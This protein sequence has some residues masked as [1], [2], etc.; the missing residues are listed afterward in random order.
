MDK[1]NK[2]LFAGK[3]F[4]Y[5]LVGILLA[6]L[7]ALTLM[8]P[9][10]PTF[11]KKET[12]KLLM[13][14][15]NRDLENIL[16]EYAAKENIKL[17]IDY[18]GTI[19]IMDKL[20]AHENYD[21]I[22]T[23]NSIW[24]Y[25]LENGTQVT[26]SKST[27]INPVVFGIKKTKAEA[28]GLVQEEI[29]TKD[30]LELILNK[31]LTFLMNA[32]TRTNTGATAYLGFLNTLA[33][34]PEVLTEEDLEQESLKENM[35]TLL[36]GVERTS[37]SEEFLE[38]LL[39]KQ[40]Y[41]AAL[42]YESSFITLNQ[43]LEKEGKEP[44]YLIYPV[45]GVTLSDSPFAYLG[46]DASKKEIFLKF[47]SY[48]LSKEG[49]KKLEALGRRT[50]Y[51]GIK[52]DTN[53]EIFNPDWGIDTTRYL[54]PVKY[55]S[56]SM[57]KKALVM[58]QSELRKPVHTIFVLDYSGSM[59]GDGQKQLYQAMDYILTE[60]KA[61]QNLVQ[62]S[63][64]DKVTIIPFNSRILDVKTVND[65][66]H[67]PMLLQALQA[68]QPSGG[69][70]F[71]DPLIQALSMADIETEIYNVSIIVMTDGEGNTGS[72]YEFADKYDLLAKKIPVYG[73][74]FGQ[75]S[76]SQLQEIASYT[77]GKVFNGVSNLL[78]AFKEVRGYN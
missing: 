44:Y 54:T 62:F 20:N 67:T 53:P 48:I 24:L 34:N 50:W 52:E 3:Q 26:N 29:Y 75:A 27:S 5:V 64:K 14:T 57:I 74:L 12:F 56:S 25:M 30:I 4:I 18:A 68:Y 37:G 23:S 31:Q 6:V 11:K 1:N 40:D 42:S 19:E 17:T 69:T 65:G 22:W 73:I 43:K 76:E 49:Q 10:L 28:L 15:E 16:L 71:Y 51:G 60:E 66:S 58:Y 63:Y 33:G 78:S 46:K 32:A 35:I 36:S 9:T 8:H 47:Q 21:A 38:E 61:S 2:I 59:Y 45:D 39:E 70:N 41:D 55:P 13:S 77:N 7:L 72:F